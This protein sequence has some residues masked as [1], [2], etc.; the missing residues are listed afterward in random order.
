MKFQL[1]PLTFFLIISMQVVSGQGLIILD[2]D[3]NDITGDTLIVHD[4]ASESLIHAYIR[5]HND[6]EDLMQVLARKIEI[7]TLPGTYNTFCWNG[8]CFPPFIYEATEPLLLESGETSA[9]DDFYGEYT[10]N[11]QEGVTI[12]DYEFF[13]RNDGFETV[14][15]T[16]IYNTEDSETF[17]QSPENMQWSL[18]EPFPNPALDVIVFNHSL[19][20]NTRE[21]FILIQSITGATLQTIAIN[22][23]SRRTQIDVSSLKSGFYLYT[24]QINNQPVETG[25]IMIGQ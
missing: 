1:L 21:A 6:S 20:H 11:G 9:S 12:I 23:A 18:S 4:D 15:T 22:P 5:I 25:K 19:P 2:S 8:A 14:K 16:V 17:T 3:D 7:D 13:S 10:P 24:F